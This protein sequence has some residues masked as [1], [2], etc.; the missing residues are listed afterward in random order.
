MIHLSIDLIG[1]NEP[2]YTDH[3]VVGF[4]TICNIISYKDKPKAA[5]IINNNK[6]RVIPLHIKRD[7]V[8][9]S[10]HWGKMTIFT[11]HLLPPSVPINICIKELE[12]IL[13]KY[14]AHKLI[15]CGDFN[16]KS[17]LWGQNKIESRGYEIINLLIKYNLDI[18]NNPHSHPTYCSTIGNSWID[19][20][21]QLYQSSA[22][23][24]DA[25]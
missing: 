6:L 17:E 18:Q 5:I 14:G 20:L 4:S 16:P 19:T 1:L 21:L 12:L 2:Y 25:R 23:L 15:I 22:R 7:Q 3:G 10:I 8:L 24:R 9:V 13:E 11:L